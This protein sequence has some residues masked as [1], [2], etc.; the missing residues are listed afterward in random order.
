MAKIRKKKNSTLTEH[1][2]RIID[3]N[4]ETGHWLIP[5]NHKVDG[6]NIWAVTRTIRSFYI[7]GTLKAENLRKLE[8]AGFP[9]D[10][11]SYQIK[12][13]QQPLID[14]VKEY[15]SITDLADV[16]KRNPSLYRWIHNKKNKIRLNTIASL[17]Y[18]VLKKYLDEDLLSSQTLWGGS[19]LLF[20]EFIS[21]YPV[22]LLTAKM[23]YKRKP[24]GR[25]LINQQ[26]HL[27]M[28]V[29][30]LTHK[31]K[32][33]HLLPEWAQHSDTWYGIYKLVKRHYKTY[34]H[35]IFSPDEDVLGINLNKWCLKQ[36][37]LYKDCRLSDNQVKLL[38]DINFEW[39]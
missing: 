21:L 23:T 8:D 22:E 19:F 15:G 36:Q 17:D 29:I 24:L 18:E 27:K 28:G 38:E 20:E 39:L 13:H 4:K 37:M 14:Y 2:D 1:I 7:S 35:F 33:D 3:F 16:N 12:M 5:K 10:I 11:K 26:Q 34:N 30:D 25:W 31:E 6:H 9:F 32:L